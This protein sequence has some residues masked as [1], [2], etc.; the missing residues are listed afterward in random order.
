MLEGLL[1][2]RQQR[3]MEEDGVMDHPKFAVVQKRVA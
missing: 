3:A 2:S 1:R